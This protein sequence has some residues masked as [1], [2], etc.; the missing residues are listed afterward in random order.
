M[1]ARAAAFG[2]VLSQPLLP[3]F[4]PDLTVIS[5]LYD[6]AGAYRLDYVSFH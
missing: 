1:A 4:G 3:A 6:A 5:G 2:M